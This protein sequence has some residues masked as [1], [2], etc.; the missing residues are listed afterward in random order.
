MDAGKKHS[1]EFDK[2]ELKKA[3]VSKAIIEIY[4]VKY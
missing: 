1:L 3:R 2:D 4:I